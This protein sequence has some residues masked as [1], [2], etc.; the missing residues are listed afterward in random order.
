[1]K[2]SLSPGARNGLATAFLLCCTA[3]LAL[4]VKRHYGPTAARRFSA[5]TGAAILGQQVLVGMAL[6]GRGAQTPESDRHVLN[7]VDV[8]TLSRGVTGAL[9]TGLIASGVRHRRGFGGWLAWTAL[10]YGAIVSD[11]LDGPIARRLGTSE[12]GAMFDIEADSWLTLCTSAAA[13]TWGG[14][15][16][17]VLAPPIVRYLRL[18]ALRPFVPYRQLVSGDPL[19]TRHVGM[20]QMT[21]FI[22]A[23]APFG[24]RATRVVVRIGTAPVVIGQLATLAFVSWRRIIGVSRHT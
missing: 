2:L 3:P 14:L 6:K 20:A 15:P 10:V 8:I 22:A 4:M 21:L 17:Y 24:G 23:L 13:V 11:W 12:V 19:W 16:A 5:G 1:M 7:L 18:A 9:I